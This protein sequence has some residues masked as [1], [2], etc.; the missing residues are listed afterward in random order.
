MKTFQFWKP[1]LISLLATPF[2]VLLGFLSAGAGEGNYFLTKILF[3]FTML[4]TVVFDSITDPF[5]LLAI[6]QFPLYG[7]VLGVANI[8]GKLR[9]S[10]VG[11]LSLH[12]IVVALC[13]ILINKNFS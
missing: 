5:I 11:L 4:S 13:F 2:F 7:V 8:M 10:E 6:V 12:T 9:A 3:P 1:V